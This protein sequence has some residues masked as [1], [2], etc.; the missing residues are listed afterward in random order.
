MCPTARKEPHAVD[1]RK[2]LLIS[3]RELPLS[4]QHV[5]QLLQLRATERRVDVRHPVIVADL[6]VQEVPAVRR[7]R[8]RGQVLGAPRQFASLV[9]HRAAAAGGDDLVAVE[10][11]RGDAAK[12]PACAARDNTSQATRRRP[13]SEPASSASARSTR[14]SM[15]G[16]MAEHVHRHQRLDRRAGAPVDAHR[17][18]RSGRS[19]EDRRR[20]CRDPRR[21]R[22]LRFPQN[23]APRRM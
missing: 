18:R 8:R 21:A 16:R 12:I 3:L 17:R 5:R 9:R 23:A 14:A 15:I 11:E 10:A 13:R 4:L 1:R 2:G 22:R 19:L 7:A 6:V 20:A